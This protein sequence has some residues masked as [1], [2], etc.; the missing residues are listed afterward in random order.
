MKTHQQNIV[1]FNPDEW[2]G[3]VVGH[4]GNPAAVTSNLDQFAETDAVSYRNAFA[5]ILYVFPA[6]AH[7]WVAGIPMYAATARCST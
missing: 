4:L 5:R 6:G 7:L 1:V 3:D 2:R